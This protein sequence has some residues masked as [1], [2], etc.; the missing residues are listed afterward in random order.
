MRDRI[1]H[2]FP[3]MDFKERPIQSTISL[4]TLPESH[5]LAARF[6]LP[7]HP[8]MILFSHPC[9]F[10]LLRVRA[11]VPTDPMELDYMRANAIATN[12]QRSL[13]REAKAVGQSVDDLMDD[14]GLLTD[15]HLT[16]WSR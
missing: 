15:T 5:A 14:K 12:K 4:F 6:A 10:V 7:Q 11:P 9:A 13:E 2:K 1:P 16:P 8:N 3:C